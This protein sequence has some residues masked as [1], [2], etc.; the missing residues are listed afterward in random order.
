MFLLS[1]LQEQE[2]HKSVYA[3]PVYNRGQWIHLF[4]QLISADKMF[5]KLTIVIG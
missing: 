4:G 3:V 5:Y 2:N 1:K